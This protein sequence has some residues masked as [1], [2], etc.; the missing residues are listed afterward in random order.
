MKITVIISRQIPNDI[1][2]IKEYISHLNQIAGENEVLFYNCRPRFLQIL[3]LF[4]YQFVNMFDS[5]KIDMLF[6]TPLTSSTLFIPS[7]RSLA[8][9]AHAIA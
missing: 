1:I 5:W 7:H 9:S 2:V 4:F 3:D 6:L 8:S